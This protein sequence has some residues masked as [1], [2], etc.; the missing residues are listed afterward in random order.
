MKKFYFFILLLFPFIIK[1]QNSDSIWIRQ[2]YIK[3][4]QYIT[5]RDGIRLFTSVYM[6]KDSSEKHPMLITRTPYSCEPYGE[7]QWKD[8]WNS[9]EKAKR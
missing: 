3:K 2:N 9:Y 7:D 5:M 4:E 8:Y 1:A 6:P